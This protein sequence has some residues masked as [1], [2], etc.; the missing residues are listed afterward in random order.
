VKRV[1]IGAGLV[2]ALAFPAT[3]IAGVRHY[4]GTVAEGGTVRFVTKVRH[5]DTVKVKRFVFNRVPMECDNGTSTVSDVGTPPPPMKVND[6]HKFHGSFDSGGGRKHLYIRGKLRRH[7]RKATGILR[8]TGD[9]RDG[10]TNCNTGKAH[11]SVRRG[12]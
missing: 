2:V 5:G 12:G 9:F 7:D 11:W 3:I 10:A 8:V 6:R 4:E 1:L